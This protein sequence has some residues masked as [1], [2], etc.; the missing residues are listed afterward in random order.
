MIA[1][2]EHLKE[3]ERLLALKSYSVLDTLPEKDFD[4]L[5]K[6]AAQICGT[7]ISLISLLD[8]HRQW[9]KSSHGLEAKETPKDL[10]FCAHSINSSEKVF[11]VPDSRKD[12]RFYDNPLVTG[13]PNVIFYAGVPLKNNKGLPLGTLCVIDNKP[14]KLTSDQIDS[15]QILGQ[16]VMNLL[17]L[18]KKNTLLNESLDILE[19]RN[20]ELERF[21]YL[22][23][24]DLKAPLNNIASMTQI[25]SSSYSDLMGNDGTTMLNYISTSSN[26][27]KELVDGLLEYSKSA[28]TQIVEKSEIDVE[29]LRNEMYSLFSFDHKFSLQLE[30]NVESIFTNKTA[31]NQVL[32]NLISNAI[33]Y[34]DK[35]ETNVKLTIKEYDKEYLFTV[36][37]NGSGISKDNQEIIFKLFK[38]IGKLDKNGNLGTGIGLATVRKMVEKM[39]GEISIVSEEGKGSKFIFNFMKNL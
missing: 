10:A 36:E 34:N 11:I 31:L 38:T 1:P 18:R 9:F 6:L 5:T 7:P 15:L 17:E 26:K 24:H 32:I 8:N 4:N 13:A 37:D 21:A 14:K 39:G 19:E 29:Y 20:K 28:S 2:V 3:K 23:A 33:K 12:E 27:L 22:A 35:Q 16:Q 30:S 25:L